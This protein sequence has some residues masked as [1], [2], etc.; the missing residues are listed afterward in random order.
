MRYLFLACCFTFILSLTLAA[1]VDAKGGRGGGGGGRPSFGGGHGGG[2]GPS[3]GG[4]HAGHGGNGG[5]HENGQDSD[6]Q[7]H[8]DH[9]DNHQGKE[10]GDDHDGNRHGDDE[11]QRSQSKNGAGQPTGPG[12]L[13]NNPTN[14]L[15]KQQQ[16][17]IEQR[18]RDHK[19]AQAQHLREIAQRNGNQNLLANADRMEAQ[20]NAHYAQRVAQLEKFGVTDPTLTPSGVT[21]PILPGTVQPPRGGTLPN[22]IRDLDSLN[23]LPLRP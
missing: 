4:S 19:I 16:L 22:V 13:V 2:G 20:A 23:L 14:D 7:H 15:K 12:G 3:G 8:A 5:S 9:S 17:L 18:N 10:H 1:P 21:N 6:K 11:H